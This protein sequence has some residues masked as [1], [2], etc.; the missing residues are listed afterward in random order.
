MMNQ[1]GFKVQSADPNFAQKKGIRLEPK[2]KEKK[3]EE[4]NKKQKQTRCQM[5]LFG[6]KDH[7][8][9]KLRGEICDES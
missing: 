9:N 6:D 4:K 2:R 7:S 5:M 3:Q 8:I 1:C